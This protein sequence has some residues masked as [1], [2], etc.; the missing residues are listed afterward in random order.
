[1]ATPA[2]IGSSVTGVATRSTAVTA[3]MNFKAVPATTGLFAGNGSDYVRGGSGHDDLFGAYGND[4]IN[5]DSGND[6][7]RG[8]SGNDSIYGSSGDDEIRGDSGADYI[9]GGDGNDDVYGYAGNDELYGDDGD[10]YIRGGTG[11][12]DIYGNVGNDRLYGDDGDDYLSGGSGAD[13]ILGNDG[14]DTLYG[15]SSADEMFGGNGNDTMYGGSGNDLMY[16]QD[17][18]DTLYGNDGNDDLYGGDDDDDLYGGSGRDGLYGGYGWNSLQGGTG[19]D[20]LLTRDSGEGISATSLGTVS[21]SDA[22]LRFVYGEKAWTDSEIEKVDAVFRV[23]HDR[24]A[25]TKL[26]KTHTG[27]EITYERR[28][29]HPKFA[30]QNTGSANDKTILYFDNAFGDQTWITRVTIHELA[31]NWDAQSE[32]NIINTFRSYSGWTQ[33]P[34]DNGFWWVEADNGWYYSAFGEGFA[35]DYA[36]TAPYEDFAEAMS[37]V[38]MDEMGLEFLQ[39]DGSNDA[40]GLAAIPQKAALILNWINSL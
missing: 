25:D 16:G 8:G 39:T 7:I 14:T 13:R 31:H 12:D 38:L 3:T 36:A 6:Y 40:P 34:P 33:N 2:T 32:N 20:R 37:V 11:N 15:G 17:G 30:A 4:V 21:S 24:T 10:D 18:D 19:A 26:L 5:G 27:D 28:I 1:M 9:R 35:S 23:L 29:S 22:V